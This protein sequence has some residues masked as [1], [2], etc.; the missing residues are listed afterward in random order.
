MKKKIKNFFL[1]IIILLLLILLFGFFLSLKKP[2]GTSEDIRWGVA[3]SRIFAE[4]LELDWQEAYLAILNELKPELLRL[5]V[6]WSDVE[7]EEGRYVFDD[8]DWMI[9]RASSTE[10]SLVLVVGKKL[11]RWPEC[12]EPEWARERDEKFKADRVA[13]YVEETVLRYRNLPN[14][15]AWQVENEPFLPFGECP[16]IKSDVLD[17][18]I[19]IVNALDSE[20]PVIVTDSGELSLWMMAYKRADIFGTTMYRIIWDELTGYV[21]YPLPPKFFWMKANLARLFYGDKPIIVSELQAEPWGP[22]MPQEMSID[23]Q[24]KSMNLEQFRGNINYARAVGFPEV[25]LWGAE[26]WYWM[27]EKQEHPEFWDE[28]KKLFNQ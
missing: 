9:D 18:E 13:L 19:A 14:L 8:Y 20:H 1:L 5:P 26:W 10:T 3:F 23:E 2:H 7:S 17:Y 15:Y 27:R 28:A 4:E 12:H 11:P 25:Y 24:F 21:R 16:T 22:H 6:Y